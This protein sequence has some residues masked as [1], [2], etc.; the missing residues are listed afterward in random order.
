MWQK[1]ILIKLLCLS[2]AICNDSQILWDEACA[3]D[4]SKKLQITKSPKTIAHN[5]FIKQQTTLLTD[6][7]EQEKTQSLVL[8]AIMNK[9]AL[10]SG[11]WYAV[12]QTPYFIIVHI[13]QDSI[14]ISKNGQN[15]RIK[16]SEHIEL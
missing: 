8:E 14:T 9:K 12:G 7:E 15:A 11:S 10:I 16:I 1:Y 6:D 3:R 13:T 5:P 4:L 2:I